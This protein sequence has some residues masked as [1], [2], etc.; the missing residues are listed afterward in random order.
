M[1]SERHRLRISD[2]LDLSGVNFDA[3]RLI[4]TRFDWNQCCC[5]ETTTYV[6]VSNPTPPTQAP[7]RA[8]HVQEEDRPCDSWLCCVFCM[9]FYN[10]WQVYTVCMTPGNGHTCDI[11]LC[12][13]FPPLFALKRC[14]GHYCSLEDGQEE[15][16][17]NMANVAL[18]PAINISMNRSI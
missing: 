6:P 11:V 1:T 8:R 9:P 10:I 5:C 14:V 2:G 13:C 17:R 15:Q 3:C 12:I 7:P 18:L 4:C 16:I